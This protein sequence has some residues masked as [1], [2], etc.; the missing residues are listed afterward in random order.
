DSRAEIPGSPHPVAITGPLKAAF[1]SGADHFSS[2][3]VPIGTFGRSNPGILDLELA[4][5]DGKL[6]ESSEISSEELIDNQYA[7]FRFSNI[8]GGQGKPFRL[9]LTFRPGSKDSMVA[10]YVPPDP[11]IVGFAFRVPSPADNFRVIYRDRDTGAVVWENAGAT[12]RVFLAPEV[13]TASSW[14]EALSWIKDIPDLTLT[15]L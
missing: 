11:S 1:V 15:V 6:I 12:P 13:R 9:S 3:Q 5:A 10:A 8:Q 2:V 14:Q 4:D 7:E